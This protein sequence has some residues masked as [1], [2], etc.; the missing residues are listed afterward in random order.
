MAKFPEMG[1]MKRR[2]TLQCPSKTDDE[3]GGRRVV[4][5]SV[6]DVWASIEPISSREYFFAQQARA[7]V[8]HKIHIRYREDVKNNWRVRYG[9]SQFLVD[10]I[11]D[12]TGEW[13]FLELLCHEYPVNEQ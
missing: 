4:Y 3:G 12:M 13:R 5:I 10:S 2:I 6:A 1:D 11:I 7:E 8:T 9:T